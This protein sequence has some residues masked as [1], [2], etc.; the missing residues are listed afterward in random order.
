MKNFRL[1]A[2][3]T[4][5]VSLMISIVSGYC[6][7]VGMGKVFA[8]AA[9]VVMFISSVIEIGRVVLLYDLHHYWEVMSTKQKIPG[10]LMLLI[11]MTLSAMGVYGFF[12]NA[13]SQRTQDIVPIEMAIKEKESQIVLINE[14]IEVN[15]KQLAQFTSKASDKL[16][17]MGYVTKALNAQKEQ[18]KSTQILYDSNRQKQE[19]ISQI[20]KEILQLQ[21]DAEQKA[22]TLA[23]IKY[24]AKLFHVD[25]E[26]AII[27]FIVMIMLVFDTLAMYLMITADWITKLSDSDYQ[28]KEVIVEHIDLTSVENKLNKLSDNILTINEHIDMLKDNMLSTNDL[29]ELKFVFYDANNS[30][31][32]I[33]EESAKAYSGNL[34][35][36]VSHIDSLKDNSLSAKLEEI[37]NKIKKISSDTLSKKEQDMKKYNKNID[38]TLE[39]LVELIDDDKSI[40]RTSIF[41][42]YVLDNPSIIK[43]LKEHFRANNEIYNMLNNL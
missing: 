22:P 32:Q 2:F 28:H 15:N 12:A 4:M 23:H 35:N 38:S 21:L 3:I 37:E 36:I 13:H 11:A 27:I 14:A 29:N 26:M 5:I 40:I 17:E 9:L 24:Y 34:N 7:V 31:K 8:S 42:K 20:K 41:K 18:M 30:T 43:K 16:T 1:S 25:D 10:V 6:T 19:E 33:V 39:K